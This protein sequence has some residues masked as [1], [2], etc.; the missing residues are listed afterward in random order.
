MAGGRQVGMR[1]ASYLRGHGLVSLRRGARGI[2]RLLA[3][4][5]DRSWGLGDDDRS[6]FA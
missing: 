1:P 3:T 4:A 5:K 2:E 6:V